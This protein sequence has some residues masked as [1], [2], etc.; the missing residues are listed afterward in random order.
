MIRKTTP[1]AITSS[2]PPVQPSTPA[3]VLERVFDAPEPDPRSRAIA[4]SAERAVGDRA[5]ER[6]DAVERA[7]L[8]AS[9]VVPTIACVNLQIA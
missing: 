6:A 8:P 5:A 7:V 4:I 9:G 1:A 2:R 3:V